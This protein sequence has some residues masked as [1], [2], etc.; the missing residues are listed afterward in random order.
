MKR[1]LL[2]TLCMSVMLTG[3]AGAKKHMESAPDVTEVT[4]NAAETT[5]PDETEPTAAPRPIAE[6]I[7]GAQT[8]EGTYLYDEC[9]VL[10]EEERNRFND[11]L[12]DISA[13]RQVKAAAVITDSL[14]GESPETFAREYF[15]TLFGDGQISGYLV[16]VNNDTGV[17]YVYAENACEAW[18]SDT[19]FPIAKATPLLVE[20]KYADALDILLV[21]GKYL[22]EWVF[23]DAGVLEKDEIQALENLA[24]GGQT[25][26]L[27]TSD[28]PGGQAAVTAAPLETTAEPSQ[29]NSETTTAAAQTAAPAAQVTVPEELKQFAETHRTECGMDALLVLDPVHETAWIAGETDAARSAQLQGILQTQGVYQAALD[30]LQN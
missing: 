25:A 11:E 26:V 9:G 29:P 5:V 12:A 20:G 21:V 19:T 24:E 23:D 13:S 22:P 18:L 30:F 28:V 14:G 2:M 6:R 15:H 3:C 16:L 17:D 1:V 4:R 27:I 10:T 8:A 7:A